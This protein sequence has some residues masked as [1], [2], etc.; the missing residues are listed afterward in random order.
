MTS[1]RNAVRPRCAVLGATGFVGRALVSD[2]VAAGHPVRVLSRSAAHRFP[3]QVE[4]TLGDAADPRALETAIAG[5]DVVFHLVHSLARSD[6][7][8]RD[9]LI[10]ERLAAAAA[11]A[12]VGQIVYLGGPRPVTAASPHLASR[13]EAADILLGGDVPAIALQAS[14]VLGRGSA[15]VELLARTARLPIRPRPRWT[16]RRSR[17]VALADVRHYLRAAVDLAP[18]R[19]R[20]DVSGPETISYHDLVRRC[21]RVLRRPAALDLPSPWW[22]HEIAARVAGAASPVPTAVAA[23]LFASLEHDLLPADVPAETVLPSLPA[24]ATSLDNALRAALGVPLPDPPAGRSHVEEDTESSTATPERLWRAITELGGESGRFPPGPAWALRGLLDQA[25]GGA[26]L[27]RGR[28]ERPGTGDVIDFWAVRHRDDTRRELVLAADMRLPGD[29]EL[30][31][32]AERA[33]SGSR[34][35]RR[36]RFTPAGRLGD[37][38][39]YLQKPAHDLVFAWLARSIVRAAEG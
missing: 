14:M 38:Y 34:L 19:G 7:A 8:A 27:Y 10:A 37:A 17:P 9:R 21:A 35:R 3:G 33:A 11:T 26:G 36:V 39:W 25:L 2:L 6:F 1:P 22:S 13:S 28:P 31:L 5:A 30:T 15:G 16:A 24:G 18:L 23:G 12:R 29:A 20:F 32:R 4:V